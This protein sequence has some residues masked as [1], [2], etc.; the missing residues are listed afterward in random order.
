[1]QITGET[2]SDELVREIFA[3]F[4]LGK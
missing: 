1:G 3:N 4:C 2:V